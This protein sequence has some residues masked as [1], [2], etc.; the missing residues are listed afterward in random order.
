[1]PNIPLTMDFLQ[2]PKCLVYLQRSIGFFKNTGK[3]GDCVKGEWRHWCVDGTVGGVYYCIIFYEGAIG[4][5]RH[6][7]FTQF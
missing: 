1:M 5:I 2:I 6:T 4:I 3:L 7:S